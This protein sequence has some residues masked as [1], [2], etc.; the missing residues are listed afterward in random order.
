MSRE[1]H[2]SP[3]NHNSDT[4][5]IDPHQYAVKADP[6]IKIESS[7]SDPII[8]PYFGPNAPGVAFLHHET[9]N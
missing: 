1:Q 3:S 6:A 9:S 5:N 4:S 2:P 8:A 7:L